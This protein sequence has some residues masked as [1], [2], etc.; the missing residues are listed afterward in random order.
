MQAL[1]C[2][3]RAPRQSPTRSPVQ[4]MEGSVAAMPDSVR[5]SLRLICSAPPFSSDQRK[6]HQRHAEVSTIAA[7]GH[8]GQAKETRDAGMNKKSL[9]VAA[10]CSRVRHPRSKA[11]CRRISP[12]SCWSSAVSSIRRRPS[13]STRRCRKRSRIRRQD[14]AGRQIRSGRPQPARRLLAGGEPGF[15]AGA[16]LCPWRRVCRRQQ[17]QPR[18]PIL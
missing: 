15:A 17:A 6:M 8:L 9:A 4:A 5:N 11:R 13:R 10:R 1:Q 16:D 14:R 12:R 3:E 2:R 18:Q 7:I